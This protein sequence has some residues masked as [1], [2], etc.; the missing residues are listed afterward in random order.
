[1]SRSGVLPLRAED[2]LALFDAATGI[3]E[4]VVIPIRLSL[5]TARGSADQ[6]PP[7]FSGLV[8]VHGRS[9]AGAAR[10]GATPAAYRRRLAALSPAERRNEVLGLV[11]GSAAEI[12]GHPGADAVEPDRAFSELG[13]DSLSAVEF[14]NRVGE[15]TGLRLPATLVFEYT[16]ARD[17]AAHLLQELVPDEDAVDGDPEEQSIREALRTIPLARLRA[18]GLIDG[19]LAL[20]DGAAAEPGEDASIDSMDTDELINLALKG[21]GDTAAER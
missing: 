11:R 4:T 21:S 12:L 10:A 19:L 9:A 17:L 6:L 7:M 13:F 18:A 15:A 2:G 3:D 5:G 20:A 8:R 1:M 16:N 14:R